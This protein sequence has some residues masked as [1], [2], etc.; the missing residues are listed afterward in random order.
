MI[1]FF[2]RGTDSL[3]IETRFNSDARKY[4]LIRHH[5]DGTRIVESFA[6]E[7]EFRQR[8]EGLEASLLNEDWQPAGSP[9]MLK[10]GWKLG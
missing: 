1:W 10:D 7:A 8:S 6:G 5:L 2:E 4:E 9:Q 3:K